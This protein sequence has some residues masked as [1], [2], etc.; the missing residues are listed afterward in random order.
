MSNAPALWSHGMTC[1]EC[2][3]LM[4]KVP[5]EFLE[6]KNF[7]TLEYLEMPVLIAIGL[8]KNTNTPVEVFLCPPP[9]E[10]EGCGAQ[11]AILGE[12]GDEEE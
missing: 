7:C 5:V 10:G 9:P 2:S 6:D 12:A 3:T 1:M 4:M 8:S 11:S